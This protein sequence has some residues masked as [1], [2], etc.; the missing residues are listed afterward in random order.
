MKPLG[1]PR[2]IVFL[3]YGTW[4]RLPDFGCVF[5]NRAVARELSG[6]GHVEDCLSRPFFRV[7]IQLAESVLLLHVG[8]EVSQ[9]HVVIAVGEQS[10][11]DWVKRSRFVATEI[12]GNDQIQ[13]GAC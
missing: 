4:L 3:R 13:R 1:L 10:I 7:R 11:A 9:V 6:T 8:G 12:V 5:V 2:R